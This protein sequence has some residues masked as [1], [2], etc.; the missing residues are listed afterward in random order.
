MR[1]KRKEI[2]WLIAAAAGVYLLGYA[3]VISMRAMQM[4]PTAI[5]APLF[6][7]MQWLPIIAVVLIMKIRREDLRELLPPKEKLPRQIAAG[8]ACGFMLSVILMLIPFALGFKGYIYTN[9]GYKKLW[10][11]FYCLVS[12]T[13]VIGLIFCLTRKKSQGLYPDVPCVHARD[14]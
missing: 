5:K 1:N 3:A 11:A 10:I 12:F 4:L 9:G 8:A 7:F 2:S 14:I 13:A 6:I